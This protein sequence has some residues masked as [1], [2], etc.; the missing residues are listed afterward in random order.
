MQTIH[1][2]KHVAT[3]LDELALLSVALSAWP[4]HVLVR[5]AGEEAAEIC[6]KKGLR[7]GGRADILLMLV[8][9]A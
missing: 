7:E 4:D 5:P 8:V 1:G 9:R 2:Q 6:E 3:A